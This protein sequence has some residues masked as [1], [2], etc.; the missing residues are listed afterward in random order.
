MMLNIVFGVLIFH[1][2]LPVQLGFIV[3]YRKVLLELC[4]CTAVYGQ[5]KNRLYIA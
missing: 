4:M 5:H 3:I 2:K 1:L